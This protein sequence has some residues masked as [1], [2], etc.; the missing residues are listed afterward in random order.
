MDESLK[1][2]DEICNSKWFTDV[3]IILFLNKSDIFAE[4]IKKIDLSVCFPDYKGNIVLFIINLLKGGLNFE[5]ACGFL[6]K[7]FVKLNKNP[8]RKEIYCHVT[9]AT[10]TQNI[11]FV[12]N[13]VKDIIIRK[14]LVGSGVI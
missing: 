8:K 4:K 7:K 6:Q 1:L 14:V 2:F 3:N 5:K 13:V 10:D 9:C 12:F 11:T